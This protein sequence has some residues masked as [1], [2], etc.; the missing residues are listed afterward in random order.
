MTFGRQLGPER[1][2]LLGNCPQTHVATM[3]DSPHRSL[4]PSGADRSSRRQVLFG[5][6][7]VRARRIQRCLQL[8]PSAFSFAEKVHRQNPNQMAVCVARALLGCGKPPMW[9]VKQQQEP[10]PNSQKGNIMSTVAALIAALIAL[11]TGTG[12]APNSGD[13]I[14]DGSGMPTQPCPQGDSGNS[15]GPAPNSGDGVPDGSGF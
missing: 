6:S 5:S 4:L 2:A 12:P 8:F 7:V 14:P 13:G 1:D 9:P 10:K 3:G 15:P 11:A